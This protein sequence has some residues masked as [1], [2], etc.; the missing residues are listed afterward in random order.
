MSA[1][2]KR[3]GGGCASPSRPAGGGAVVS[4]ETLCWEGEGLPQSVPHFPLSAPASVSPL[5]PVSVSP[6][7]PRAPGPGAGSHPH[8][9]HP[10]RGALSASRA[11]SSFRGPKSSR[12]WGAARGN[13]P[14]AGR[15]GGGGGSVAPSR[16]TRSKM[17][18]RRLGGR[19]LGRVLRQA[20]RKMDASPRDQA[21]A[22]SDARDPSCPSLGI[23]RRDSTGDTCPERWSGRFRPLTTL[24]GR[25]RLQGLVRGPLAHAAG[26]L[27][28]SLVRKPG[29]RCCRWLVNCRSKGSPGQADP[30]IIHQPA[31]YNGI[32]L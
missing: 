21:Q 23:S 1:G 18:R 25:V 9:Q 17:R 5:A 15:P 10:P 24:R 32:R 2:E 6:L 3:E 22:S 13:D 31:D 12:F 14:G 30:V 19:R 27:S 26:L 28:P 29:L 11:G 8:Q 4:M 7:A 16:L 20:G